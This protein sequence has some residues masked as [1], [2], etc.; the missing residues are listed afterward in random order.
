[1]RRRSVTSARLGAL[2]QQLEPHL[3]RVTTRLVVD[4]DVPGYD[5]Y[6]RAIEAF[7]AERLERE[8]EGMF[9]FYS[10]GTTGR[11]K[12]I[13]PPRSDEAFGA[14][15]PPMLVGLVQFLYGMSADTVYLC[16]APLYHAA[17]LGWTTAVQRIGGKVVVM[18]KFEP[19]RTLALIEEHRV[20]HA[21]FVPTHFV[22][23]L[24]LDAAERAKYDLS[25]LRTAVHAAAP[26]PAEV[27]ERMLEWWGRRIFEYYSGS[28]GSGFCAIGPDEWLAHRGSVGKPLMGTI[29]IVDEEGKELA[30]WSSRARS[31]SRAEP[32]SSTTTTR[33]RPRTR[34]TRGAGARSA[35]SATSTRT[36][37]STSRIASRT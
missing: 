23:M 24:K 14:G 5:R 19:A 33:R 1:M 12:G 3:R 11:P 30:D 2:A 32:G 10:S 7:P 15:P 8:V 21:Q 31:G 36:A 16:P 18:E 37:S 13:M 17:P 29:H 26:C 27:K 4:A 35:T 25:S 20:T 34:S 6:E 28:E 9:M 22:R